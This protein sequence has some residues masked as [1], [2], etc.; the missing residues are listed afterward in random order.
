VASATGNVGGAVMARAAG[1]IVSRYGAGLR[2]RALDAIIPA[3][4]SG[5][6]ALQRAARLLESAQQRGEPAVAAAHYLLSRRSPEYRLMIE[7]A[8]EEGQEE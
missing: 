8:S 4:R 5:S 6:P 2:V 7:N 3:M 1:G